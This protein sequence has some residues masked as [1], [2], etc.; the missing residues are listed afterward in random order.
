M[1]SC[2]YCGKE[3][4]DAF[5]F[6]VGCGTELDPPQSESPSAEEDPR[7]LNG[8]LATLILFAFLAGELVGGIAG[9][10][11]A[12]FVIPRKSHAG[13][14]QLANSLVTFLAT[15]FGGIATFWAAIALRIRTRDTSPTGPAWVR[16]SW[17][18]IIKGTATGVFIG[19]CAVI[20]VEWN[21]RIR[22]GLPGFLPVRGFLTVLWTVAA[23]LLA[24]IIEESLFRGVLYGG[25]R[26]SI[27]PI[28]ATILTTG[29]FLLMH[30]TDLIYQPVAL[31]SVT[32]G[33]LAMLW[34]RL[35]SHAI[36]PA[37]AVHFGYNATLVVAVLFAH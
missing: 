10:L 3:N 1:K 23:V 5:V 29:I 34:W 8:K 9:A 24:P 15:L 21:E 30:I 33:A 36:G 6:C 14:S 26:Q 22:A 20:L 18:D 27:G 11:A 4:D 7:V 35:R 28:G 12:G 37:I 25:Y 16:G 2:K 19:M 13:Y 17:D 31:L 32:G